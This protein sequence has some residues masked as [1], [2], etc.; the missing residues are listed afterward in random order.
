M[1]YHSI[2]PGASKTQ[3]GHIGSL[4]VHSDKPVSDIYHFVETAWEGKSGDPEH[5][6]HENTNFEVRT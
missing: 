1:F 2:G 5:V 4:D 3:D 6:Y